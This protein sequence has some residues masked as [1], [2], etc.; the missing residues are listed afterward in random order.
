[1]ELV[2]TFL[3][4]T[5]AVFWDALM[6]LGERRTLGVFTD[7][8]LVRTTLVNSDLALRERCWRFLRR[9]GFL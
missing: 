9:L 5:S 1:V 7:V 3:G 4:D 6:V 2:D 8:A